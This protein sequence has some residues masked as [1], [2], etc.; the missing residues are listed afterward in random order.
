[1]SDGIE[2][3]NQNLNSVNRNVLAVSALLATEM[4]AVRQG[5]GQVE[6]RVEEV[7]KLTSSTREELAQLANDFQDFLRAN[8]LA[9]N[10]QFAKTSIIEVRQ[11][12]ET[13]FGHHAT[14][15]RHATGILQAADIG[16]VHQT[17]IETATEQMMLDATGYWLAPG[18]VALSA[19]L[20]DDRAL[21]EKAMVCALQRDDN[22]ASLF[23]SLVARRGERRQASGTWLQRYFSL[24]DPTDLDRELVVLIDAVANGVFGPEGRGFCAKQF[25]HWLKELTERTGF[26]EEQRDRWSQALASKEPSIGSDEYPYL[27]KHCPVWSQLD[28]ALRGS[29]LHKAL[30]TYFENT[31]AGE[32]VPA[33]SLANAVDEILDKLVTDYDDRELPARREERLLTLILE[34][35]GDKAAAQRKFD[36]EKHAFEEKVTFTQLITNAAM[37]PEIAGATKASQRF[38]TAMSRDWIIAAHD[39]LTAKNRAVVPRDIPIKIESWDGKTQA[40]EN[41]SELLDSI[42][43]HW[44]AEEAKRIATISLN[45][46]CY[47]A[48]VLGGILAAYGLWKDRKST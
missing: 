18:L 3:L 40:G 48:L 4:E 43:S 24:Q 45:P 35:G 8:E 12:L 29:R 28:A 44:I 15:R 42:K 6:G 10:L 30:R 41:E 14:V 7:S 17:T 13:E 9:K 39:D 21:A 27:R 5:L 16:I 19:W 37:H 2:A 38:A 47:G 34:E 26:T 20:R 23:F 11:R 25:D 36:A 1:M 31:F 46:I 33:P 32:I 22:K